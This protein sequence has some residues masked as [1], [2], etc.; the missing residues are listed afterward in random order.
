LDTYVAKRI[1]RPV[2]Q[3][4]EGARQIGTGH[5]DHRI[6]PESSDEFG[7]LAEAFN[8]MAADLSISQ[9]KLI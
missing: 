6:E 9:R 5:L 4:A 1:T 8:A 3:L 7:G 2:L